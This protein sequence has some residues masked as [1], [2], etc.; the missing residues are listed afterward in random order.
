MYL[1][2]RIDT[3]SV[4]PLAKPRFPSNFIGPNI[5]C[6]L[7]ASQGWRMKAGPWTLSV[8]RHNI[9]PRHPAVSQGTFFEEGSLTPSRPSTSVS[10]CLCSSPSSSSVTPPALLFLL[11]LFLR[12]TSCPPLPLPPSHLLPSSSSSSSSVTPPARSEEHTS[13]LQSR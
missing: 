10:S 2:D 1:S 13:E 11:L 8:W 4:R 7:Q 9:S 3:P 12:H 5:F 6:D